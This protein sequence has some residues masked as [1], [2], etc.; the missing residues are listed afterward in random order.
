MTPASSGQFL[1][2]FGLVALAIGAL[3]TVDTF[4]AKTEEGE[5]RI[6]AAR[7]FAL[8]RSL[9]NQGH[10]EEAVDRLKD[11]LEIKR[12]NREYQRVLAQA[13]LAAGQAPDAEQTLNDLLL[14]DSTDGP[15]NLTMGRVLLKEGRIREAISYYHRAVYG[16]WKDDPQDNRLKV[17]F[18]L[19]D[20]LAQQDSKDELLAEL[21]AVQDQMPGDV[22]AR[23]RLGRL[24]LTAGS[25]AR[26]ADV[27]RGVLK[28]R[29]SSAEAYAGLGESDFTKGDY[30]AAQSDFQ[31]ALRINPRLNSWVN[32]GGQAVAKRLDL[33][34]RVLAL[35]PAVRGIGTAERFRRSRLLVQMT[36]DSDACLGPNPAPVSQ[37]L[38]DDAR[39][40]LKARVSAAGQ[41]EATEANLDLA[42]RLWHARISGCKPA[43]DPDDPLGLVLAKVAAQ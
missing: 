33:V 1:Q 34:S 26:A 38:L 12:G 2:T 31:S 3:F 36:L 13:Q 7:L 14:G 41:D 5:S 16:Q 22:A 40:T 18:E 30:R 20:L 39:R 32:P 25:P 35:D 6:E 29:P 8:G 17:R 27:F 15:S 23:L 28:D 24:F 21:L 9:L 10:N 37:E 11:A 42:G 4:L 43:P 19:I